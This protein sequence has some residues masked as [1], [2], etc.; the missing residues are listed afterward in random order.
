VSIIGEWVRIWK[1][2]FMGYFK[3]LSADIAGMHDVKEF[4]TYAC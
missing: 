1:E 4:V 2:V 3:A